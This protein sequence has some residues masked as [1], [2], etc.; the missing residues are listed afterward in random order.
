MDGA[1]SQLARYRRCVPEGT[2]TAIDA[3]DTAAYLAAML[4]SD[5]AANQIRA[6]VTTGLFGPRHIHKRV[7]D[8][9]ISAYDSS[10]ERHR[11]LAHLGARLCEQAAATAPQLA[12]SHNARGKM[13]DSLGPGDLARVEELATALI[14]GSRA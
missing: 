7:L 10:D 3:L 2:T 13:R 6:F 8:V 1:R 11:A 14:G 12:G 4:R 9:P 5:Q